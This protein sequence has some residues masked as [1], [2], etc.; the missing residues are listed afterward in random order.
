MSHVG[1]IPS[2]QGNF[3]DLAGNSGRSA[4]R[5]A[6]AG[7]DPVGGRFP[8][9]QRDSSDFRFHSRPNLL[10][11]VGFRLCRCQAITAKYQ[12]R[13]SKLSADYRPFVRL[14]PLRVA[15]LKYQADSGDRSPEA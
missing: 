11:L 10:S 12:R 7:S 4:G 14:Q 1:Q 6:E 8:L 9:F 13:N 3:R 15:Y 5:A 2:E